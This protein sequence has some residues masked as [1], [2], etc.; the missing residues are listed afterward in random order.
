MASGLFGALSRKRDSS[1]D[2]G[3]GD[4]VQNEEAEALEGEGR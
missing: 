3:K 4:A 2:E 1:F